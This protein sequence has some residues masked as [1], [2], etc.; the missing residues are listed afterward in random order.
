MITS[1]TVVVDPGL[2]RGLV[3]TGAFPGA[4]LQY[5]IWGLHYPQAGNIL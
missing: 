3:R 1:Q 2:N 5:A 4:K